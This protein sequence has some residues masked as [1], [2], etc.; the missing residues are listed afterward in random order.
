MCDKL[1]V[2]LQGGSSLNWQQPLRY[3]AIDDSAEKVIGVARKDP[4]IIEPPVWK[5]VRF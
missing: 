3:S 2:C 5:S 1:L 4:G